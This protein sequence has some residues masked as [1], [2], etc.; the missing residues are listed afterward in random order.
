MKSLE[1][2]LDIGVELEKEERQ[3]LQCI[4][5]MLAYLLSWFICHI[6]ERIVKEDDD[7]STGSKVSLFGSFKNTWR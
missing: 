5:K 4:N 3:R 6:D 2:K 1:A 7:S